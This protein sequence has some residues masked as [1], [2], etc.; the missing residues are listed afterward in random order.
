M[1]DTNRATR[2]IRGGNSSWRRRS[3]QR[4]GIDQVAKKKQPHEKQK[5]HPRG[6]WSKAARRERAKER[7]RK[8]GKE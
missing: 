7:R 8:L 1:S 4:R 5:P 3:S 2:M 6:H